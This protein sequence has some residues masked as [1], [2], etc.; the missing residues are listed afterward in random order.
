MFVTKNA[1]ALLYEILISICVAPKI[2]LISFCSPFPPS[3][4]Y[5]EK[6]LVPAISSMKKKKKSG[7]K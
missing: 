5:K 2:I 7:L 3:S 4:F 1:E 6:G